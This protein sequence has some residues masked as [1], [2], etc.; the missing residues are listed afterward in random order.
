MAP[1]AICGQYLISVLLGLHTSF[2]KLQT[3]AREKA[4][5]KRAFHHLPEYTRHA[6]H[7]VWE[8]L[9]YLHFTI[10]SI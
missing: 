7:P 6:T 1:F 9:P 3:A 2:H 8:L 5:L 10:S 4:W